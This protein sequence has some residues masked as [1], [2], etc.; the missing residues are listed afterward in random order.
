LMASYSV[1]NVRFL[2]WRGNP[3]QLF[4]N[5]DVVVLPSVEQ[6]NLIDNGVSLSIKGNE[7]FPRAVLEGMYLGKPVVA[8]RVAGTV[9]QIEDGKSG[10]LVESGDP[11]QLAEALLRLTKDPDLRAT[12]GRNAAARA[13]Q[14]FNKN[15]MVSNT[16]SVFREMLS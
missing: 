8:S 6:E 10:L 2:G 7:G 14:E 16:M 9:E 4:E 5:A 11:Q 13:R 3:Q 1:K 15:R 12:L